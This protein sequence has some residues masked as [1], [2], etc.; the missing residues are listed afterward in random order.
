VQLALEVVASELVEGYRGSSWVDPG[1]A[2]LVR[3]DRRQKC[4][5]VVLALKRLA[6]ESASWVT[7]AG[8]PPTALRS[9]NG[10]HD[11]PVFRRRV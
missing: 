6:S 2:A 4:P 11:S 5:R 3:L 7:I 8:L 10:A 9:T 1:P